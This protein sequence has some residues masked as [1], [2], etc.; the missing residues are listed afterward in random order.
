M[1]TAKETIEGVLTGFLGS[2]ITDEPQSVI[3][4]K[5]EIELLTN[6]VEEALEKRK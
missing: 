3:L 4:S 5:Y 6:A 1:K 2:Q